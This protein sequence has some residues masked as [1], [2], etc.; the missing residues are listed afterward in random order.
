[1]TLSATWVINI[2][3]NYCNVKSN[4]RLDIFYRVSQNSLISASVLKPSTFRT[5]RIPIYQVLVAHFEIALAYNL[6]GNVFQR[7][8]SLCECSKAQMCTA[9]INPWWLKETKILLLMLKLFL[10]NSKV[11]CCRWKR[12]IYSTNRAY[13]VKWF[14]N[15]VQFTTHTFIKDGMG[16]IQLKIE[17]FFLPSTETARKSSL[18][19]LKLCLRS[20]CS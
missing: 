6:L 8:M 17:H 4:F 16:T 11:N 1:M 10:V 5:L 13:H 18:S 9:H 12:T 2:L 19:S 3:I 14:F 15:C 20:V 7:W